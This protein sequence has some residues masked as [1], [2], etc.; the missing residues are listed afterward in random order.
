MS[1]LALIALVGIIMA[2]TIVPISSIALL[3]ANPANGK[4]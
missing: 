4:T 1:E 3:K 2:A